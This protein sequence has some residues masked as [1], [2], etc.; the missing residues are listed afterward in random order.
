MPSLL[1]KFYSAPII[2]LRL[3]CYQNCSLLLYCSSDFL[4]F[5]N[6][7]APSA[8]YNFHQLQFLAP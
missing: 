4:I 3:I 1:L 2:I 8:N 5:S 7:L 6:L